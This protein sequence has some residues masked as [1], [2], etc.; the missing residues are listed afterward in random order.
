MKLSEKLVVQLW[1][2]LLRRKRQLR[3]VNG[4]V[5]DVVSG[6]EENDDC[7][8]DFN[9]AVIFVN[10]NGPVTGDVEVHVQSSDWRAHGHQRDPSYNKVVLHV[11]LRHDT[12]LATV[13]ENSIAVPVISVAE[14]LGN[15]L[16]EACRSVKMR[17]LA[18]K[19]CQQAV[20]HRD[21]GRLM[22][23]LDN[24]GEARFIA[25]AADFARQM[26][27]ESGEEVLYRGI[28]DALGYMR[29]RASFRR[30]SQ[31]RSV[32]FLRSMSG[33]THAAMRLQAVLLGTAGLLPSQRKRFACEKSRFLANME[34]IWR[35][36]GLVQE[37]EEE[38]WHFF[39]VR[40]GNYP[41]R[42]IVALSYL[43][44]RYHRSGMLEHIPRVIC[45]TPDG[46]TVED[47]FIVPAHSYWKDHYDCGMTG[48]LPTLLGRARA[49]EIVQ[50]IILPFFLAYGAR[51]RYPTLPQKVRTLFHI[52]PR[53][54]DNRI[55]RL[56][57]QRICSKET[58]LLNTARQQGLIHLYH[59]YCV[60]E[61]CRGCPVIT[62][63]RIT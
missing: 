10:G 39:K 63:E 3:A 22:K 28:C 49:A 60:G 13:L 51:E 5:I 46:K 62:G 32:A 6:G 52:Y 7:G 45:T 4:A 9:H 20:L 50:N 42:R 34:S 43:M 11:V 15:A 54:E 30:L 21:T 29:N 33:E 59:N 41:P 27:Q 58:A 23:I 44:T 48:A 57:V 40:P 8:P 56:M 2:E 37:M 26:Q 1:Q 61:R 17:K 31:Y 36:T 47:A 18:E 19:P 25:K 14:C 16:D 55:T 38:E 35:E 53:G 24:A 12:T